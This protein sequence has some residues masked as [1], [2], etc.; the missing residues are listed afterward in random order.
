MFI[1]YRSRHF[2]MVPI[3]GIDRQRFHG[4]I[5]GTCPVNRHLLFH[6]VIVRRFDGDRPFIAA[7]AC[8]DRRIQ[9]QPH[10]H[11]QKCNEPYLVSTSSMNTIVWQPKVV[12]FIAAAQ[13]KRASTVAA[14]AAP[15]HLTHDTIVR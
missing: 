5:A 8:L 9:Y 15:S 3:C 1:H 7:V 2:M 6:H 11:K 10:R 13:R 14:I 4:G 12:K